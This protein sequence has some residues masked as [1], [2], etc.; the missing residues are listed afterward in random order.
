[1]LLGQAEQVM[2]ARV[3]KCYKTYSRIE[4]ASAITGR[5]PAERIKEA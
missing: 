3:E 2:N 4:I 1:M 5:R